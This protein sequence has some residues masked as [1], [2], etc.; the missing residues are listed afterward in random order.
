[1]TEIKRML[2]DQGR[3]NIKNLNKNEYFTTKYNSYSLDN[4]TVEPGLNYTTPKNNEYQWFLKE[5]QELLKR[6]RSEMDFI[7]KML[8]EIINEYKI[9]NPTTKQEVEWLCELYNKRRA[10]IYHH[11]QNNSEL[12]YQNDLNIIAT[13]LR[14]AKQQL[15]KFLTKIYYFPEDIKFYRAH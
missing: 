7:I 13:F 2:A 3:S 11:L 8:N 1:M 4:F 6:N 9:S 14:R 5:R 12:F 15:H 10:L